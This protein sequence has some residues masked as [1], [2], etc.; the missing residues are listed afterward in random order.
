M[1]VSVRAWIFA[2]GI[3]ASA[4][5]TAV[6]AQAAPPPEPG[7]QVDDDSGRCTAGF[8]AQDNDGNYYLL[9]ASHC[10]EGDG[11][12]W[13]YDDGDPLGHIDPT[14][15]DGVSDI[16][17]IRLDPGTPEPV[18]GVDGYEIRDVLGP[19][20]L[21]IGMPFCK[22]GAVTGET[23]GAI[24]E[25]DGHTVVASVYSLHGDSGSPGFVKNPD[26][27]VSAVGSL[28]SSPENDDYTTNFIMVQPVLA[29]WGLHLLP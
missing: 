9:T 8:A 14:K 24:T 5:G 13:T 19:G 3:L 15:D 26:G 18:G 4:L 12:Q 10:D 11:A 28:T 25:I 29:L 20:Q 1:V 16:S 27:T 7:I 21:H 22:L 6:P 23:C 17:V 2:A